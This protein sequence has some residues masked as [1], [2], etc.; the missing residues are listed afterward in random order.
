MSAPAVTDSERRHRP[1]E[2]V[3]APDQVPLY[4]LVAMKGPNGESL[5]A[6]RGVR[7][8][9]TSEIVSV[10]S[11][12][13]QL[14]Q[15]REVAQAVHAIGEALERPVADPNA[16]TFPREVIRLF[17]GGRR[18][19]VRLVVGTRYEL[20]PL[21]SA[22]PGVRVMNSLD[23]TWAVRAEGVGVRVACANQL[24]AGM[25]S[26]VELREVHLSSAT[27]LLAMLSKAIHAILSRFNDAISVYS[28]A[29]GEEMLAEE[30]APALLAAGLPRVH[31][32][33]IG[34]RA[35]VAGSHNALLTKWS[36]YQVATEVLTHEV[37]P[38]VS[39]ER[40]R[41]FERMAAGA[42]LPSQV[43][44]RGESAPVWVKG[45]TI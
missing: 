38:R 44:R 40:S 5:D 7:R 1:Y 27:D 10:V 6:Y 43:E 17:A 4:D 32:S 41:G 9:D 16:P 15:H 20:G 45:N 11:S 14:V 2:T 30:V 21:D 29:M 26:L 35:E 13:Y 31:A 25:N 19:E 8:R 18:M 33:A 34:A 3:S 36:A 42:L 37:G 22:Y 24:Y 28:N 12:R 23:G 39:P